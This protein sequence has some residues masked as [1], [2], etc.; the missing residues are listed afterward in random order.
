MH[1]SKLTTDKTDEHLQQ[2]YSSVISKY[3]SSTKG[4]PGDMRMLEQAPH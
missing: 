4:R 1:I 2:L 3:W